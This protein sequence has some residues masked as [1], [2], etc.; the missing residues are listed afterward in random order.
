MAFRALWIAALAGGLFSATGA[1]ATTAT[2][3]SVFITLDVDYFPSSIPSPPEVFP[4]GSQL[5]GDARFYVQSFEL[6]PQTPIDIGTLGVGGEFLTTFAPT[7]ACIS[8]GTCQ[9]D[10]SFGGQTSIPGNPITPYFLAA[11]FPQSADLTNA[12]PTPPEIMPIG[13]LDFSSPTPPNIRVA[14]EIVAFD[15]PVVV[16][17]WQVTMGV[18]PLPAALP[19]FATGFGVIGLFGWRRKKN[20]AAVVA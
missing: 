10:F 8:N 9:L 15:D 3:P 13:T 17:T 5:T 1:G 20:A 2:T 14:G 11:A 19:L 18:T 4:A 16:G 6:I 7:N 12:T